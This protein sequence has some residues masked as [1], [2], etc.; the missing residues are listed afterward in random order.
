[1]TW[2]SLAEFLLLFALGTLFGS[3]FNVV[4]IRVP[5]RES[6]VWPPS[7]CRSCGHRLGI[8]DLLPLFGWLIRKG[9]CHYCG[10]RISP[11][12]FVGEA[13]AGVLFAAL[14]FLLQDGSELVIAYP[15]VSIV[16]VLTVSDL[17]YRLLPN[18]IIYPGFLVFAVLRLLIHPL[19]VWEY[20][21]G[22]LVGGGVLMLVSWVSV[23]LGKPAMGGGDIK[24]MALMGLVMGAK[25]VLLCLFLSAL[26]GSIAGL[27]MIASGKLTRRSFI[28]YG[29]FIAIGGLVSYFYGQD[30]LSWYVSTFGF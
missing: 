3:F 13:A 14:P 7:C 9:K 21:L 4:G 28:P 25:L 29:P 2:P 16:V 8:L 18:R 19:P 15:L 22:F 11:V 10:E 20:A 23:L 24:M 12:Y 26:F 6:F 30:V 1:M 17:N 27:A 5:L